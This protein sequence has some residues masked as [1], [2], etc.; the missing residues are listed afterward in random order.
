MFSSG[1]SGEGNPSELLDVWRFPEA[2]ES[3]IEIG[4]KSHP[5]LN[6]L[7]KSVREISEHFWMRYYY[8]DILS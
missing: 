6:R 2:Q 3:I 5:W 8:E 4:K 7:Q 1:L